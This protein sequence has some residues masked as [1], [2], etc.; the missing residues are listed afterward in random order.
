MFLRTCTCAARCSWVHIILTIVFNWYQVQPN[1]H[2][3]WLLLPI[4]ALTA[5]AQIITSNPTRPVG[6]S[7]TEK[8]AI[9]YK[10]TFDRSLSS[11]LSSYILNI[12]CSSALILYCTILR[13]I[14]NY[15]IARTGTKCMEAPV[16]VERTLDHLTCPKKVDRTKYSS[17]GR[18]LHA[19][20]PA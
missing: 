10:P 17:L 12:T 7:S 11:C 9:D 20:W 2:H 8:H 13:K 5:Y 16:P 3:R 14:S 6:F 1:L 4:S 18:L 19:P 15:C